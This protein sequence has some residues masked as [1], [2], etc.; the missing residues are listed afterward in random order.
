M[1][2]NDPRERGLD[3]GHIRSV[4]DRAAGKA[5][6]DA[7]DATPFAGYVR[8]HLPSRHGARRAAS[9]DRV[10]DLARSYALTPLGSRPP[11]PCGSVCS[12]S[13]TGLPS[14]TA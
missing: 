5:H 2:T 9:E 13:A 7:A 4:A 11:R 1:S 14:Q 8:V 10:P 3:L 12:F 6:G